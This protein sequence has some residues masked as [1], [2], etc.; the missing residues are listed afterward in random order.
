VALAEQAQL[1]IMVGGDTADVERARPVLETLA[2]RVF[3]LGPVTTGA[4]LKLAVNTIVYGLCQALSEGLVLAERAGIDRIAAYEVI[5]SSAVGA[6]FVHYRRAE[7]ESP[8]QSP[9]A[10]RLALAKKDLDLILSLSEQ[11]GSPM[12]QAGVNRNILEA[13]M[14]EGFGDC[15][16]SAVAEFLRTMRRG[17]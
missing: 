13:A 17:D 15:D 11:M 8:G 14:A 3:H 9:V 4:T 7:F 6:P 2:A 16:V 5:A 1:T 10:F 12:P